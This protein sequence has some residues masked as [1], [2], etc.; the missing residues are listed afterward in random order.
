MSRA[1][2]P[3]NPSWAEFAFHSDFFSS[4]FSRTENGWRVFFPSAGHAK[5]F[6]QELSVHIK[7]SAIAAQIRG[8]IGREPAINDVL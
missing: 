4:L 7:T 6:T 3:A 8:A 5:E 1:S 2:A